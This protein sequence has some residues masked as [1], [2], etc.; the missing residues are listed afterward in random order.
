MAVESPLIDLPS[1]PNSWFVWGFVSGFALP[2][3]DMPGKQEAEALL[4]TLNTC[5]GPGQGEK[6]QGFCLFLVSLRP[7][8]EG[9]F[10]RGQVV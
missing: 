5:S 8:L 9:G 6:G 10:L 2:D 7:G 1:P 3:L 4:G